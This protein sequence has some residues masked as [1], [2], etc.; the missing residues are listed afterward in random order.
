MSQPVALP[1][2]VHDSDSSQTSVTLSSVHTPLGTPPTSPDPIFEVPEIDHELKMIFHKELSKWVEL[3][4]RRNWK[5]MLA[6]DRAYDLSMKMLAHNANQVE[7]PS[8]EHMANVVFKY[9]DVDT[10]F[11][12][13]LS[14]DPPLALWV[15]HLFVCSTNEVFLLSVQ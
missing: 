12:E 4:L 2:E 13:V 10:N 3:S 14:C 9:K 6:Y 15:A 1:I 7:K 8:T 11:W 5:A